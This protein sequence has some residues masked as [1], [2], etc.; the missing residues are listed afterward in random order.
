MTTAIIAAADDKEAP[1][2]DVASAHVL[3]AVKPQLGE[4]G[5]LGP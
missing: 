3:R 1:M 5:S 4:N 2:S